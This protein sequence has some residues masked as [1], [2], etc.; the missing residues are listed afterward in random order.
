MS[1]LEPLLLLGLA[2]SAVSGAGSIIGGIEA[3]RAAQFEARQGQ[4]LAQWEANQLEQQAK[5]DEFA[6][7]VRA[8]EKRHESAL[9]QSQLQ[10]RAASSGAGSTNPTI[11]NLLGDIASRGE[12]LAQTEKAAGAMDAASRRHQGAATILG[13]RM[14]ADIL[15]LRG[16]S[17]Q[18]SG[19]ISGIGSAVGGA[20]NSF[21]RFR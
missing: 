14:Q 1:G 3:N 16:R 15:R 5:Q 18:T 13:S 9:V 8:R 2:G 7:A 6:A 21:A 17:A 12:F 20:A 10:A 11:L 19:L 4:I